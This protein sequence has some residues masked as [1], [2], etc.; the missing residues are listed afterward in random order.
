M[1]KFQYSSHTYYPESTAIGLVLLQTDEVLESEIRKFLP[2]ESVI[3]RISVP[4]STQVTNE[5]LLKWKQ[6][7]Q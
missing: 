3:Y 1:Q 7:S 4:S 2:T 5:T 6:R